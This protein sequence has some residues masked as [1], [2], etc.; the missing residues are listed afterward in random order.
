MD[1][2]ERIF[3]FSPDGG[4]GTFELLLFVIPIMGLVIIAAWRQ[5][6]YASLS[7]TFGGRRYS[8]TSGVN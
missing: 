7:A 6:A 4:D 1:F 5:M 2:I 3:G 8:A